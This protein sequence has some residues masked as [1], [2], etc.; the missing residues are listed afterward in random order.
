MDV[1]LD[2]Y[3]EL[4]SRVMKGNIDSNTGFRLITLI[5]YLKQTLNKK[6]I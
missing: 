1:L 2:E 3:T 5:Q 4:K 6:N